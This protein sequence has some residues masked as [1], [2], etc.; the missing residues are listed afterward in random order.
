MDYIRRFDIGSLDAGRFDFQVLADLETCYVIGCRSPAGSGGPDTHVHDCDQLYYV[1]DGTMTVALGDTEYTAGPD[2]LVFIPRGTAH[3]NWAAGAGPEVHIDILVPPPRRGGAMSRPADRGQR[4]PGEPCVCRADEARATA[5]PGGLVVTP[6]ASPRTGTAS[7]TVNVVRATA[8]A[9]PATWHIHDFDQLYWVLEGTLTVEIAGER[10][11]VTA[12]HLVVL[13]AGVPHRNWNAAGAA[14][15]HLAFLVPAP[16]RQPVSR[17]VT[18]GTVIAHPLFPRRPPR[19]GRTSLLSDIS[20]AG[21]HRGR[22][23]DPGRFGFHADHTDYRCRG[24]DRDDAQ[25]PAGA[26]GPGAPPP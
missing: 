10:H 22:Q 18:F 19:A 5:E 1:L 13:H 24:R 23:A 20:G 21:R 16:T 9:P 11:E 8:A 26:S 12:G 2:S 7:I 25:A 17:P 3:R 6:I 15:R 4:G 14:E